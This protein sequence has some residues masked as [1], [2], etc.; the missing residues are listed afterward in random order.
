VVCSDLSGGY[1]TT[2]SPF[3][4]C[5]AGQQGCVTGAICPTDNVWTQISGGFDAD[6]GKIEFSDGV[7]TT[8]GGAA[9]VMQWF[10]DSTDFGS[11]VVSEARAYA[12][13]VHAAPTE[14]SYAYGE[15][16][17]CDHDGPSCTTSVSCPAGSLV[18]G[19][20]F[21]GD[22]SELETSAPTPDRG[23]WQVSWYPATDEIGNAAKGSGQATATCTIG[24]LPDAIFAGN[25]DSI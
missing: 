14:L 3:G 18:I 5:S 8:D 7:G 4:Y 15:T 24:S 9:W 19:G 17:P 1:T 23:G 12:V 21:R 25:F 20:G 10:A 13:C 11:S 22:G 6:R 16:V 2:L